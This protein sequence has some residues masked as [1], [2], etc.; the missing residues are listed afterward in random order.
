M[1]LVN[2]STEPFGRY[3]TVFHYVRVST[4]WVPIFGGPF[5]SEPI[6]C[7]QGRFYA[8][9][10]ILSKC[11]SM[12]AYLPFGHYYTNCSSFFVYYCVM[13]CA[14][15]LHFNLHKKWLVK[16]EKSVQS[17]LCSNS[18]QPPSHSHRTIDVSLSIFRYIIHLKPIGQYAHTEHLCFL[19]FSQ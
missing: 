1:S 18:R 11:L 16:E 3:Q 6:S 15:I 13:L 5:S 2:S 4:S 19:W 14:L 10:R 8:E 9:Y 7:S 17:A 12:Y